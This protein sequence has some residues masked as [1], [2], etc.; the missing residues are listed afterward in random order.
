MR[1]LSRRRT[2]SIL[3][4]GAKFEMFHSERGLFQTLPKLVC[5]DLHRNAVNRTVKEVTV[6]RFHDDSHHQLRINLSDFVAAYNFAKRL[7][8]LGGLTALR[9]HLAVLAERTA[10]ILLSIPSIKCRD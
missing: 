2:Q 4:W 8:S 6:Q 10:S 7:K 3:I 1:G 5:I 9:I